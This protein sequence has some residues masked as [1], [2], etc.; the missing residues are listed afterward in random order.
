MMHHP[1]DI[2]VVSFQV[3]GCRTIAGMGST[4]SD[5]LD[6]MLMGRFFLCSGCSDSCFLTGR[7]C[8][9]IALCIHMAQG[10]NNNRQEYVLG[11]LKLIEIF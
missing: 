11:P 5:G 10:S 7:V 8:V 2:V 9:W 3:T 1:T 4:L 6:L